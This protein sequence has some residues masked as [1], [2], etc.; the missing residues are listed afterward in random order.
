MTEARPF[1]V[2]LVCLGNICR[3]PMAA[4][5]LA[6]KVRDAGLDDRIVVGS[7][8]TGDWHIGEPM[9]PRAAAQLK[10]EGYDGSGHRAKQFDTRWFDA[11]D[12]LLAMDDAN[13]TDL[14]RQARNDSDRQRIRRFRDFDPLATDENR[15]VPDPW[16]GDSDGFQEVFAIVERTANALVETLRRDPQEAVLGTESS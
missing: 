8:G 1:R 16:Y 6:A 14:R 13:A 11:Y 15:S 5:V 12:L 7:S 4:V 3:S 2:G 9:D 10:A